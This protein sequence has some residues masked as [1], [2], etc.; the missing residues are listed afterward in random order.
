MDAIAFGCDLS[1]AVSGRSFSLGS[2][3]LAQSRAHDIDLIQLFC[4]PAVGHNLKI[5]GSNP[6]PASGIMADLQL[7]SKAALW[8]GFRVSAC[9]LP[10]SLP[11]KVASLY[12]IFPPA[13]KRD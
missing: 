11:P 3:K 5:T 8:G 6:V 4:V 7:L 1:N 2:E 10:R 9:T 13:I 12:R